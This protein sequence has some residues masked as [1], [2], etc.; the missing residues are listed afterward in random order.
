MK[1]EIEIPKQTRVTA[2]SSTDGQTDGQTDKVNP[3]CPPPP[4]QMEI[5]ESFPPN[6]KPHPNPHL[7]ITLH[8]DKIGP[9][10]T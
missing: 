3:V 6:P 4:L 9:F 1:F 2:M 5:I 10:Q 7:H 8:M